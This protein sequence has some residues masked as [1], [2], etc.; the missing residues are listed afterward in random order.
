M[1]CLIIPRLGDLYGRKPIYLW[2]MIVQGPVILLLCF[3]NSLPI[4]YILVFIFGWSII[5]R[6]SCGF[7]LLMEHVPRKMQPAIGGVLMV[8]EGSCQVLWATYL[9]FISQDTFYFVYYAAT[10]GIV[11][12]VLSIWIPE[13]PRYLY[14]AN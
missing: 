11:S 7:L 12:A 6:M 9:R 13:S 14:G 2:S 5:G 8:T 1:G 3:I 10:L 4:M